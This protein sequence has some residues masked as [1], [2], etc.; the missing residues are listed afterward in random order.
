VLAWPVERV[1]PPPRM[2]SVPGLA[3]LVYRRLVGDACA[4]RA[5]GVTRRARTWRLAVVRQAVGVLALLAQATLV[6]AAGADSWQGRNASAHLEPSG[7]QLHFAHDDATCVACTTQ[8]LH[9]Q[10]VPRPETS[11]AYQRP[12]NPAR[13]LGG[14][15]LEVRDHDSNGSRA[16][17]LTH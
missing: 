14:T 11:P 12:Q 2:M 3:W 13:D 5:P 15:P 17:P 6:V 1:Y 16:P 4:P 8:T 7:T 10:P 9:A